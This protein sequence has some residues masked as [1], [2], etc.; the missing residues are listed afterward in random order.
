MDITV[1]WA[2]PQIAYDLVTRVE[3]NFLELRYDSDVAAINDS[4]NVLDEH[5]KHELAIVD[6]DLAEFQAIVAVR[7]ASTTGVNAGT[8]AAVPVRAG[9]PRSQVAL[10]TPLAV[11]SDL[12]KALEEKRLQDP[13]RRGRSEARARDA[14]GTARSGAAHAHADASDGHRAAAAAR[15]SEPNTAGADAAAQRGASVQ[16]ADRA[17]SRGDRVHASPSRAGSRRQRDDNNT[18]DPDRR[19]LGAQHPGSGWSL[20]ARPGEACRGHT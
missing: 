9:A 5:A 14:Q 18:G 19:G 13:G 6:T 8:P 16:W 17:S 1:D 12:A 11:D 2:N 15:R 7:T 3:K 10:S 20:A 4:V